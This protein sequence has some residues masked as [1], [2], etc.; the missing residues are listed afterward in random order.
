M[1]SFLEALQAQYG[2]R[3]IPLVLVGDFNS[4]PRQGLVKCLYSAEH[5]LWGAL[6][7]AY[8]EHAD[9]AFG[10][11]QYTCYI[12]HTCRTTWTT[13]F[14]SPS[15]TLVALLKVPDSA[16]VVRLHQRDTAG[17]DLRDVADPVVP[18]RSHCALLRVLP[19]H[20]GSISAAA[21][22]PCR[23]DIIIHP[24]DILRQCGVEFLEL[25]CQ[26]V[27]TGGVLKMKPRL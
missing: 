6:R 7:E 20:R 8:T 27:V 2:N 16:E 24:Q 23:H 17:P 11:K 25:S 15:L 22:T 4:V 18:V 26:K 14:Y 19:P 9:D 13:C 3:G 10:G 21:G 5:N 1:R 12:C